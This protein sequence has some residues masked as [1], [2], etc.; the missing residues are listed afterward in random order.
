MNT[1]K[2]DNVIGTSNL[3]YSN[4]QN[5]SSFNTLVTLQKVT[6]TVSSVSINNE[7]KYGNNISEEISS[8]KNS[9]E[10]FHHTC[11]DNGINLVNKEEE[12]DFTSIHYINANNDIYMNDDDNYI[13]KY[14]APFL[15][16]KNHV[17][18]AGTER[19]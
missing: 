11:Y 8:H 19:A 1:P 13:H 9:V 6:D 17:L 3:P 15:L 4:V 10:I 12:A 16:S 7:R 18:H 5:D 14:F 2:S